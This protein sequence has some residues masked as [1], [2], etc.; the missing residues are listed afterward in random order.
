MD[1]KRK[2]DATFDLDKAIA[3]W[4]R[5][6]EGQRR[7]SSEDIDELERHLRDQTEALIDEGVTVRD[8][9]LQASW[10]V[11]EAWVGEVEYRKVYWEKIRHPARM[12][13]EL[14]W[15]LSVL[16]GMLRSHLIVA[17]RHLW[18]HRGYPIINI[19]GL[20]CALACVIL[21][22]ALIVEELRYVDYHEHGDRIYAV[23]L[24]VRHEGVSSYDDW[25]PG[26]ITVALREQ[27]PE[28]EAT[29][30][31][32]MPLGTDAREW[33]KAGGKT[34]EE[35]FVR[36]DPEF[37][38]VFEFG[39]VRG[40]LSLDSMT[41]V[42]TESAAR[43]FFGDADP[44]GQSITYLG[45]GLKGDY[46]ITGILRDI[47][48]YA[49]ARIGVLTA[50]PPTSYVNRN[51]NIR[52]WEG[53]RDDFWGPKNYVRLPEGLP[54]ERIERVLNEVLARSVHEG[55]A[56]QATLHL[57]PLNTI[58]LYGWGVPG[59][60]EG[61]I[62]TII[63]YLTIT[64]IIAAVACANFV[65]L[66]VARTLA[67]SAE[68]ATRKAIGARRIDI[69]IQP[70]T[71]AV[72]LA[73]FALVLGVVLAL[74]HPIA[75]LFGDPLSLAILGDWRFA[76]GI[77]VAVILIG[78]SAGLY[79]GLLA[80]RMPI[81]NMVGHNRRI[82]S[83]GLRVRD[84]L[85]IGQ[86]A[87]S[88][89]F[90]V[91]AI[92][93]RQQTLMM[94][95]ADLGIDSDRVLTTGNILANDEFE[96]Q[97]ET[98]RE[99]FRHTPGVESATIMWPGPGIRNY[100]LRWVEPEDDPMNAMEMQVQAADVYF[101]ETFGVKLLAGRVSPGP[102]DPEGNYE[103]VLNETAVARLG[104]DDAGP[105][106]VIGRGLHVG[107][108]RG[109]VVGIVEDFHY[110]SLRAP[111]PPLVIRKEPL[112]A[113]AIR[114][115]SENMGQT[116]AAVDSTWR[117]IFGELPNQFRFVEDMEGFSLD[118][119]RQRIRAYTMLSW[120]AILLAGFGVY[121]L[122]A[123]EAQQR[124]REVG[125]RKVLGAT[126]P[127]IVRLFW[128][129]HIK[130]IFLANLI[131]LPIAF[132][133]IEAWLQGFAHRIDLSTMPFIAASTAMALLFLAIVGIQAIKI[134]QVAPAETLR[135]E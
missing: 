133:L 72:V 96:S 130:L 28:V 81:R 126:V 69:V 135:S 65:N 105:E 56:E 35:F 103:Y 15:G 59:F 21:V 27:F 106:G 87:C 23:F 132:K 125:V 134:G 120:A 11:G 26:G 118:E 128:R 92:V 64:L 60:W 30:R 100:P 34:L 45:G 61:T 40:E 22:C 8:A 117:Q 75:G 36:A 68:I 98:I 124:R 122:A 16:P 111:V 29:A 71:E 74:Y 51:T 78:L 73:C 1:K 19:T 102:L 48:P 20:A 63:R 5:P 46:R 97:G 25:A 17:L 104:W 85:I 109:T 33:L 113:I 91:S 107:G 82:A 24:E 83:T 2:R 112:L 95:S 129:D 43:R 9:F 37:L 89:F 54:P 79:P 41:A 14:G 13:S 58:R 55:L 121:G 50:A 108:G 101:L 47:P 4:R 12:M 6:Y 32:M 115:R 119:E 77:A 123:Y 67:R 66:S 10:E 76:A 131:A 3:A 44:V 18:R 70:V 94:A 57:R 7:Y 127:S 88:V 99:A 53:W 116:L 93:I 110:R 84:I 90:M 42:I 52:M 114:I 31:A 86:L 39:F 80:L 49:F 62:H 38:D